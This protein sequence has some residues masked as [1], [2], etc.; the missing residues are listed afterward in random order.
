MAVRITFEGRTV[1]VK[2]Q[3]EATVMELARQ[4]GWSIEARCG[5]QGSCSSCSVLLGEGRYRIFDAEITVTAGQCRE[6]LSCMTYVLDSDAEIFL[7][8]TA[9]ISFDGARIADDMELPPHPLAPRFKQGFGLAVD[10]GT[11]TVSAALIDL[12]SGKTAALESQY[13]QQILKADDVVSRISLCSKPG[14]LEKLQHLVIEHTLNPLIH[15][16][17]DRTGTET[18]DLHH[19]VL[20]GNTVMMHIFFGV[21]P[22][23]I[24]VLPFEPVSRFFRSTAGALDIDMH[25]EALVEDIPAISGYVGGDITSDLYI[26]RHRT[27]MTPSEN[28]ESDDLTLLIDIGTNGEMVAYMNGKMTACATA[29]GPAFE[30]AGLLHGARAANRAIDTIEFDDKLDFKLTVIGETKPIGLCGSAIIDFIAEGFRCGLINRVG[31]FDIGMLKQQHRYE[32]T[33]GMHACTLVS[34]PFSATGKSI[35]ITEGDIAE[36]L[37]AKAAIYGGL[38][39]LLVELGK[40]V[41]DVD[42]IILAGGFAKYINLE[43]AICIGLL[44]DIDRSKYDIIGNGSLAGATLAVL[45]RNVTTECFD[46]IDRPT[47]I[48]LNK[49]DHFVNHYQEALAIPNLETDDFPTIESQV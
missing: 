7:P 4:A 38:K 37:K 2:N 24:G 47:V 9:V 12:E 34:P 22:E 6:A 15:R 29:A 26:F 35:T 40:T 33:A 44:P 42:R 48:T 11:T 23:S 10:V 32:K 16:L 1:E 36:I 13:N 25:P 28:G 5:G 3:P 46:I 27:M 14:E 41:H 21:S 18:S 45:D 31:R 8:D 49:T 20:S 43:N 17:C 39:S 30:G 19:L